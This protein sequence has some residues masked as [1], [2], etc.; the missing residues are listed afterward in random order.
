MLLAADF[1]GHLPHNKLLLA[2]SASKAMRCL[3]AD[4]VTI[5]WYV[6]DMQ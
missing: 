2:Q 4:A 5:R 3:T 1:S 6:Q